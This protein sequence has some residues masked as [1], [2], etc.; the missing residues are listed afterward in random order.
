MYCFEH[1]LKQRLDR[2][3]VDA[4]TLELCDGLEHLPDIKI[5]VA[6]RLVFLATVP[7][8]GLVKLASQ[9]D[10]TRLEPDR[11]FECRP[12]VGGK[13]WDQYGWGQPPAQC[14]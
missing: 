1:T 11:L 8:R 12:T 3:P 14:G 10:A 9:H 4:V 5:G 7:S 2:G 13:W 6:V